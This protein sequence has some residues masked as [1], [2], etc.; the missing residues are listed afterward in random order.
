[1]FFRQN[2]NGT[3]RMKQPEKEG[4][5][6]ETEKLRE[7]KSS[8]YRKLGLREETMKERGFDATYKKQVN[9]VC[10]HLGINMQLENL[11]FC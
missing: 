6:G 10:R 4:A 5:Q 9:Y 11:S 7:V 2:Q 1:M 8:K 3:V